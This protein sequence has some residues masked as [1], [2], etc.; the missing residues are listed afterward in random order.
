MPVLVTFKSEEKI[1]LLTEKNV[2]NDFQ[3]VEK[4]CNYF[5]KSYK[6]FLGLGLEGSATA[7]LHQITFDPRVH[8][9]E[10]KDLTPMI[11]Q[12]IIDPDTM[13]NYSISHDSGRMTGGL[14]A[15]E[16]A[17]RFHESGLSPKLV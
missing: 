9:W 8:V 6:R 7:C 5:E 12:K 15:G 2:V 1:Y 16:N 13:N 10:H 17:L 14:C 4:A 11:D 3:T